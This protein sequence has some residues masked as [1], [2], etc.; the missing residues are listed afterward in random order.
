MSDR[1]GIFAG[2]DPFEISKAW[3]QEATVFEP[4]DANAIAL[5]SVDEAGLPNVRIVLLKDIEADA[6][7]FY[8]NY[9]SAKGRE[10]IGSGQAAFVMHW[11]SLRRQIRVRGQIEKEDGAVSDA[12]YKSRPLGSKIGAWASQQSAPLKARQ[13]LKDQ[14]DKANLEHG[15]NPE[16]PPHWGGFRLSPLEIEFWSDG[17]FRLHDRFVWRRRTLQSPWD[18]ERISP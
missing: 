16:R 17:E 7:I 10:L 5:A 15:E 8:T 18:V 13:I 3:L 6:F 1:D 9:Q 12:Y 11:K 4:N 14:V 2:S